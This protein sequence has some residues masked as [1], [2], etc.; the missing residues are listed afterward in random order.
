MTYLAR[1]GQTLENHLNNVAE[2]AA[3]FCSTFCDSEFGKVAGLLHDLGKYLPDFQ[4]KLK[5]RHTKVDHSIIGSI[6]SATKHPEN[7]IPF[8]FVIAGHH[9]GL[10]NAIS[11]DKGMSALENRKNNNVKHYSDLS[12]IPEYIKNLQ[13]PTIPKKIIESK[14]PQLALEMFT[15]MLFS[16]LVDAD[17]LDAE[18]FTNP[19]MSSL[20]SKFDSIEKI[21]EIFTINL[22]KKRKKS[23]KKNPINILREDVLSAC[24]NESI[25]K[26][27]IY[28]LTVPTGGGKTLS[29]MMFALK[30]AQNNKQNRIIYVAPFTSIIEQNAQI[31]RKMIGTNNV[32]EHHSNFNID[33]INTDLET[34]NK[35][36]LATE[37]WDAPIVI[38]TTVQ[39]FESLFSNHPAQC[40]KLHNIANSVIILDEVQSLPT[41]YLVAILDMMKELTTN[42]KCSII[43][44]TATQPSINKNHSLQNGLESVK[45]IFTPTEEHK[46]IC[47]RVEY[48]FTLL[49]KEN[50]WNP[51]VSEIIKHNTALVIVNTRKD[52]KE[53]ATILSNYRESV[54]HLSA[55][56]VPE[57]RI[58][59]LKKI[60][61]LLKNKKPCILVTTQLIEAGVDIDFPLVYRAMTGLDS[62][63]QAAGR[64]NREGKLSTKGNV[65]LFKSPNDLKI[66]TILQAAQ[67]TEI[68]LNKYSKKTNLNSDE[69]IE[70]YFEKLYSIKDLDSL[71]IQD[72]RKQFNFYKVSKN[73]QIIDDSFTNTIVIPYGPAKKIIKRIKI[74]SVDYKTLRLLQKYTVNI[75][76]TNFNKLIEHS[77]IENVNG[78]FILS[79]KSLYSQ[80]YGL[81]I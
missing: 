23:T 52:A 19:N 77:Y 20:R 75:Y 15:R 74:D 25:S 38:T 43:L 10:P 50:D 32:I 65:L 73:F 28:S 48:D 31:Y 70:E 9:S 61:S 68:I 17:R 33:K 78:M 7:S 76:D 79:N 47:N 58:K 60:R 62:I 14:N 8:Q 59:T 71:K 40:R 21:L 22:N 12:K 39:F 29:S 55:L 30:H 45:Q 41:H 24:I 37:N 27:G 67:T 35:L 69:T 57:H 26:P 13:L 81:E 63:V 49:K 2:L 3:Q 1:P 4:D 66:Q 53:L 56:M 36:E 80:K 46:K 6:F 51:L 11:E 64:C 54:Y 44:S 34:E 5:G 72:D 18:K 42:Y 16:C